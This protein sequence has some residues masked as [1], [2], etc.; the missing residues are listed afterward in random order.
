MFDGDAT[1]KKKTLGGNYFSVE[2]VIIQHSY[3]E[4]LEKHMDLSIQDTNC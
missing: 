2:L 1:K 4:L 3:A